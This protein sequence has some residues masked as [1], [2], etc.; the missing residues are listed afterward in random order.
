MAIL[1]LSPARFAPVPARLRWLPVR[2][3]TIGTEAR[4][5]DPTYPMEVAWAGYPPSRKKMVVHLIE[6][7]LLCPETLKKFVG[8]SSNK[9]RFVHPIEKSLLCPET[10][11]K[12]VGKSSNMRRVVHP[13]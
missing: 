7:S 8:K 13:I 3:S 6:K 10:L 9:R 1:N 12:F 4:R 2:L 11:K 5:L